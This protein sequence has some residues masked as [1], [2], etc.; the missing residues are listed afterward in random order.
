MRNMHETT[1]PGVR[2]ASGG[3]ISFLQQRTGLLPTR[4]I[5]RDLRNRTTNDL[6][7]GAQGVNQGVACGIFEPFPEVDPLAKRG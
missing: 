5:G 4:R 2:Y 6:C 1:G 3:G 7:K